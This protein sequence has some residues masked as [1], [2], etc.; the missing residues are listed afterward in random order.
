M[1]LTLMFE[2]G[3]IMRQAIVS[4][5]SM[6]LSLSCAEALKF[7]EE[8][9]TPTMRDLAERLRITAPSATAIVECLAT[10][11]YVSRK[12]DT[13][14]RRVTR[15]MLTKKGGALLKKIA[16]IKTKTLRGLVSS[17]SVT[18]RKEFIKILSKIVHS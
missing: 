12:V 2:V 13:K 18:D 7:I 16:R 6:P 10:D 4:E 15:L 9:H 3:R 14:D 11:G 8:A 17:L 5:S 1:A